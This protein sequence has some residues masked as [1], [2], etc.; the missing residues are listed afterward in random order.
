M[1]AIG[2][3]SKA[4]GCPI[5]TIRYYEKIGLLIAPS[6]TEGGHRLYNDSHVQRLN[7]ILR[8]RELGFT[9]EDVGALLK[10]SSD[11]AKPCRD[12]LSI[13]TQQLNSVKCKIE[14]LVSLEA[15]LSRLATSC[16]SCCPNANAPECSII[17]AL[18]GKEI[19]AD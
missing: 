15:V 7:F 14:K 5:E 10:L 9:L 16:A 19:G 18:D 4:T 13:A 3:L 12:V 6:R 2:A 11:D 17:D 8:A 1:K